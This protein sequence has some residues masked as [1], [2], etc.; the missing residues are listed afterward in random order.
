MRRS[1]WLGQERHVLALSMHHIMSDGRSIGVLLREIATLYSG[2]L[3]STGDP[4]RRLCHMAASATD[5][6]SI[7]PAYRLLAT[8]IGRRAAYL[9]LPVDR[10][11]R[12]AQQRRG[13]AA[14]CALPSNLSRAFGPPQ[15]RVAPRYPQSC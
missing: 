8:S 15:S 1:W 5:R 10:A 11:T 4:V 14:A 12:F 7:E 6:T 9:E 2:G 3:A 13:A